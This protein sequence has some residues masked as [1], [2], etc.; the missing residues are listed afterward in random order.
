MSS[1]LVI[2]HEKQVVLCS[3]K[4]RFL[5]LREKTFSFVEGFSMRFPE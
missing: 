1:A 2:N 5:I 3:N 4:F